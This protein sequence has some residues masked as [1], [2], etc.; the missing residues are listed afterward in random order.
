[1]TQTRKY[2]HVGNKV[3]TTNMRELTRAERA[4]YNDY[5]YIGFV[6]YPESMHPKKGMFIRHDDIAHQC[7]KPTKS[8]GVDLDVDHLWCHG[9]KDIVPID[10]FVW[11]DTWDR[12]TN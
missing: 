5:R 9:C 4:R 6:P 8:D 10:Q 7:G 1:M 12:I 3:P 11:E 2:I